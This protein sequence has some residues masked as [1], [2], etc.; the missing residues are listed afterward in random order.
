MLQGALYA[1]LVHDPTAAT[2]APAELPAELDN[3]AA[4][5]GGLKVSV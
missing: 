3:G 5:G 2:H 1:D 4:I